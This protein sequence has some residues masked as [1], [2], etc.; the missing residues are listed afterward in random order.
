MIRHKHLI[1][2]L[3]YSILPVPAGAIQ[4]LVEDHVKVARTQTA[5]V[6]ITA[7]KNGAVLR[8][9]DPITL[10]Y[11]VKPGPRGDHVHV[12][13]DRREVGILRELEGN[14]VLDPLPRGSHR[15]TIKIVNR[16]HLPIGVESSISI[17]VK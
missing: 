4:A 1:P 17:D 3:F 9:E 10:S 15:L 6:I 5:S 16:D 2:I 13:V 14:F 11:R 12:Y 7:P 8:A